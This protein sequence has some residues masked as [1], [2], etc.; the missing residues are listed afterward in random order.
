MPANTHPGHHSPRTAANDAAPVHHHV[1]GPIMSY[2]SLCK[3][4]IVACAVT[5][6]ACD[7]IDGESQRDLAVEHEGADPAL[8]DAKRVVEQDA[9][10][11]H[12][13][14]D[15]ADWSELDISDDA[16]PAAG[17][18]GTTCCADCGD[19]W[20]GWYNLGTADNCNG[21]ATAFCNQNSWS[22]INAE[23]LPYCP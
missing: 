18:P 19:G 7:G 22:I 6:T 3:H 16:D 21:R 1:G 12:E 15:E 5:L 14:I 2:I 8:S 13:R 11:E 17:P 4:L 9:P 20:S 23:W 10:E